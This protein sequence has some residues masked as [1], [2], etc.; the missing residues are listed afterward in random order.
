MQVRTVL[1]ALSL[2]ALLPLSGSSRQA[3]SEEAVP[4]TRPQV[5]VLGV[6]HMASA[7]GEAVDV[8][9]PERQAEIPE[10]MAVLTK[11]QP[12]KVA[13]EAAFYRDEISGRYTDYLDGEHELSRNERQQLG[14][15]LARELGHQTV[16]AIDADGD[17]PLPRL[18]DYVEA[19]GH[20]EEYEA[21]RSDFSE[22]VEAWNEY[23][24]SHTLLEALLYMNSDD[25]AAEL[26][27]HDYELAHFGEP[28]NWA[29]PDLLSAWFR[30][31]IRIYGN[32]VHLADS[33]DE[34]VLVIIGAGH[35]A[36]LRHNLASDPNVRL[37][38]LAELVPSS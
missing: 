10:L 6:W 4:A 16:Y 36:W 29:G 17:Y 18:Q 38:K 7:R 34:R 37:R 33:S 31:N 14:F 23:L 21:M 13:L 12:T 11:F 8:L 28:W 3:S 1:A 35:L 9:S 19:R 2:C 5:L 27:A 26:M 15:R 24:A 30:R 25:Y 32:I 22:W 20:G